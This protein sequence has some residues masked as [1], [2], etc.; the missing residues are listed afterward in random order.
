MSN[1]PAVA[2]PFR[3][4]RPLRYRWLWNASVTRCYA[5]FVYRWL[6]AQL[7]VI[8]RCVNAARAFPFV[9]L[10]LSF[11]FFFSLLVPSYGI[12]GLLP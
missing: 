11:F 8:L 1:H 12:C 3:R 10:F 5:M 4:R 7:A 6:R 9:D 2:P